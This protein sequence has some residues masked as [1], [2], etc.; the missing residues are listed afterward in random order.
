MCNRYLIYNTNSMY[1]STNLDLE[2]WIVYRY[3]DGETGNLCY[4]YE[5][6]VNYNRMSFDKDVYTDLVAVKTYDCTEEAVKEYVNS[7]VTRGGLRIR[8]N[9]S[10]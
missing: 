7:L 2:K 5:R 9:S 1:N 3:T 8:K 4:G 6:Y 10:Q